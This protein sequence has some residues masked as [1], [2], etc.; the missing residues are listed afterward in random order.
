MP[1]LKA[2]VSFVELLTSQL[3]LAQNSCSKSKMLISR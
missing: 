1:Y 3:K 2:F